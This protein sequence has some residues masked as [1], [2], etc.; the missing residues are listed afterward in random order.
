MVG[1]DG[2]GSL[3]LDGGDSQHPLGTKH[4]GQTFAHLHSLGLLEIECRGCT[5]SGL[6][7][8]IRGQ[9]E[10]LAIACPQLSKLR[11]SV[12]VAA[13]QGYHRREDEL[14]LRGRVG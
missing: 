6:H 2:K 1:D 5:G 4:G 10:G 3:G 7:E 9:G 13:K 11:D 14:I 8:V 12:E